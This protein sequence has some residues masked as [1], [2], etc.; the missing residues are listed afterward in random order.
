MSVRRSK[1]D[2]FSDLQLYP[3]HTKTFPLSYVEEPLA[4]SWFPPYE[5]T[6]KI[7]LSVQFFSVANPRDISSPTNR[8]LKCSLT[9]PG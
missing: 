6:L 1:R 2:T 4:D 5:V 7:N 9:F 3:L 8:D